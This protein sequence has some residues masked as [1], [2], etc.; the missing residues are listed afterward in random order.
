MCIN[1][2]IKSKKSFANDKSITSLKKCLKN[3]LNITAI[4]QTQ[5]CLEKCVFGYRL[6]CLELPLIVVDQRNICLRSIHLPFGGNFGILWSKDKYDN[7]HCF[8]WSNEPISVRYETLY[9]LNVILEKSNML[10]LFYACW[11]KSNKPS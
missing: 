9:I 6:S 5:L 3:K 1:L 11:Y 7:V 10:F 4:H 8:I 2:K